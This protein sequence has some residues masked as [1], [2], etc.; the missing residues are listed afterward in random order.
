M[1]LEAVR[2]AVVGV[3]YWGPNL[4]RNLFELP[5]AVVVSVCDSDVDALE[6]ISRR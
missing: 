1:S 4:V 5:D 2:V 6:R 3:G